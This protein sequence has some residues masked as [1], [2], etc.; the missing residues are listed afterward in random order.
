MIYGFEQINVDRFDILMLYENGDCKLYDSYPSFGRMIMVIQGLTR[1]QEREVMN[2]LEHDQ[3]LFGSPIRI[4][5]NPVRLQGK[6]LKFKAH[7]KKEIN[8]AT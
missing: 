4:L 8:N 2:K 7:H 5:P 1:M 3:I 6:L